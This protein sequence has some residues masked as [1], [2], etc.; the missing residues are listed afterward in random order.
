[1][2]EGAIV[3]TVRLRYGETSA[4]GLFLAIKLL[5]KNKKSLLKVG[6]YNESTHYKINEFELADDER[7]VG[8]KSGRRGGAL[9]QHYDL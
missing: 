1:M 4:I 6:Y 5:D 2:P 8:F 7:I 9:S 3:K